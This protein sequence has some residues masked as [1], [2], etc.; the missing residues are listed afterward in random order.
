M[1]GGVLAAFIKQFY[2]LFKNKYATYNDFIKTL[3]FYDKDGNITRALNNYLNTKG[4][5]ENN[6]K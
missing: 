4:F 6:V 5:K 1:N 3:S 2:S